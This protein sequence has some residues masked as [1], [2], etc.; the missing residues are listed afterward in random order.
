MP[1]LRYLGAQYHLD[2]FNPTIPR[3]PRKL[4]VQMVDYFKGAIDRFIEEYSGNLHKATS[5]FI[6][7]KEWSAVS[8]DA[9]Q[10]GRFSQSAASHVATFLFGDRVCR[11]DIAGPVQRLCRHVSRWEIADDLALVRLC[12]YL[13]TFPDLELIGELSPDD[14]EDLVINCYS[15]AD[16]NGDGSTSK[17]TDG[18][19]VELASPSSGRF[20]Q[21]VWRSSLQKFTASASA[22]SETAGASKGMRQEGIPVQILMEEMLGKRLVLRCLIDNTQTI[23]AI[24]SGYSKRLRHLSRTH[25]VSIGALHDMATDPDMMIKVEHVPTTEQ[26]ADIFTKA[27][28][29]ASFQKAVAMLG[30]QSTRPMASFPTSPTSP[31][32]AS[33]QLQQ[34]EDAADTWNFDD[35]RDAVFELDAENMG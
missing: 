13:N 5:P 35:M 12:A 23:Q 21:I 24:K 17:S 1:L 4:R 25:R 31:S 9:N 26:K 28:Q 32:T 8:T 10:A 11:P 3:A 14:L 2:E 16:W 34:Q 22:E 15:D 30:L 33:D 7:D 6:S 19:W 18:V 29:P 27:L 20:F